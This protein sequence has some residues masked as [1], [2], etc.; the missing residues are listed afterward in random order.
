MFFF[1]FFFFVPRRIIDRKYQTYVIQTKTKTKKIIIIIIKI[2]YKKKF[3]IESHLYTLLVKLI[4]KLLKCNSMAEI[5]LVYNNY[6]IFYL[7][8][9]LTIKFKK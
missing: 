5:L 4:F 3:V 6:N 1:F 7:I 2:K 9:V 8:L